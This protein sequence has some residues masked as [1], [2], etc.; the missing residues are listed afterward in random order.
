ANTAEV[1]RAVVHY[2]DA[3]ADIVETA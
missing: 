2:I 1:T 3:K